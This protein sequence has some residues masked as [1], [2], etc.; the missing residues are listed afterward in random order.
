MAVE[1]FRFEC[2]KCGNCCTDK[3]TIVNVTYLDILR[4]KNGLDF[5]LN[6][7]NEILGF[8]VF[9]KKL[10]QEEL[11]KMVLSP[12][13]T[14]K[15]LAFIGLMKKASGEC[16][17]FNSQT[18]KCSIYTVRPMFCRTF[19]FTFRIVFDKQDKTKAKIIMFYTEK[20]KN[21]CPGIGLEAPIIDEKEWI[22][23]GKTVI[24]EMN[25]NHF[26]AEKWNEAVRKSKITPSVK[27]FLLGVFKL[28]EKSN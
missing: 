28:K 13:E 16:Y 27:N 21:Y 1:E 2:T 26:I 20:G 9:D 24:E 6:E 15:G 11:K 7:V 23:I 17:F 3:N 12:I 4:I 8:Y 18:K 14:E 19:P 22:K 10:A 25:D 5:T